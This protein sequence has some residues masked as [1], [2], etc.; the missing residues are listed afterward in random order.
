MSDATCKNS[1]AFCSL[2]RILQV[3][4]ISMLFDNVF[5]KFSIPS[6]ASSSDI[7]IAVQKDLIDLHF[8][9]LIWPF[10]D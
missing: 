7:I 10:P 1:D 2:I 3:G 8:A 6:R 9:S 5:I 4:R